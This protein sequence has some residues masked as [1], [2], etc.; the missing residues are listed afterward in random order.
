MRDI[1]KKLEE[2]NAEKQIVK[3]DLADMAQEAEK[4]HEVQMARS[5]LYKAAKYSVAIHK[6]MKD[7]S[8]MQG[9]EGWVASKITKAADYL[10]SVKHYMEGEMMADVE[11]AVVPVAGDMTDAMT[12]PEDNVEEVHEEKHDHAKLH[13]AIKKKLKDEGGAA[14]MEPLKKIAKDMDIDLTPAML[15][16]I[17]GVKKHRDGDYILED[18]QEDMYN[19]VDKDTVVAMLKK[20]PQEAK[21]MMQAG[22]VFSIYGKDLYNELFDYMA[23]ESGI[24]MGGSDVDPVNEINDMLDG[25]D[26]LD[27]PNDAMGYG[28]D[29]TEDPMNANFMKQMTKSQGQQN[30]KSQQDM[31]NSIIAKL[32]RDN[33]EKGID[34]VG[35]PQDMPMIKKPKMNPVTRQKMVNKM[36]KD[37]YGADM[38]T[39][40]PD[41]RLMQSKFENW[42]KK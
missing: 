19:D 35:K 3:E 15:G 16:K 21:K 11:L 1:I 8:E 23:T 29:V 32:P 18:I 39:G 4:D 6:M 12:V 37:P 41:G 26:L 30:T 40:R 9:I 20:H 33:N 22:D 24:Y 17:D 25:F 34:G 10:G 2:L 14:G 38:T 27:L 13:K 31:I 7:V 28:E 5:D 42:G 36:A